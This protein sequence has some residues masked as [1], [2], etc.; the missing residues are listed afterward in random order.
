MPVRSASRL[1]HLPLGGAALADQHVHDLPGLLRAGDRLVVNNTRVMAARLRGARPTGGRVELVALSPVPVNT[2][3]L[4]RPAR[5][6]KVGEIITLDSGDTVTI[7]RTAQ[8]GVV[9][10]T[11]SAPIEQVMERAGEMPL[12]PYMERP[13][14]EADSDRYQTVFAGPLGAAAAPTAGLHFD[15]ALLAALADAG[16]GI[17][18]VTLHVGLGTF[19]PLREE[20]VARGSL[21]SEWCEVTEAAAREIGQ[22]RA[23]GGRIIAI[24]TTSARTLEASTPP[25]ARAPQPGQ[26][27]TTLFIQPPHTF[28]GLDGLFTNFHLPRSSLLMM[29]A[30]LCGKERLFSAYQ[31]AIANGY[32]FY[33]YGDAMLLL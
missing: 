12:P 9:L 29:V 28:R 15:D 26:R 2:P 3:F 21:H 25:G 8:E 1:L 24:G 17:S 10:G 14:D 20:D 19:R 18:N 33:S 13:A 23:D 22:T 30:C 7:T 31:H 11:A 6:L 4:A 5:K 27:E 32:R 16:V